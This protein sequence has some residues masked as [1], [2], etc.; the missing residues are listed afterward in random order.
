MGR[1]HGTNLGLGRAFTGMAETARTWGTPLFIG[2]FGM[3]AEIPRA[4]DY[5]RTFYDRLDAAM[6]SGAQWN[7]TPRWNAESRDGWNGEDFSILEPTGSL[8]ANFR[9][10]PYPRATAGMPL[11]FRYE[12]H[13]AP[14][15][16]R[17]LEF[18]WDHD[19]KCGE[20]EIFVPSSLF[21]DGSAIELC[22]PLA[23]CHRDPARQ[24][25]VC[26]S[27]RPGPIRLTVTAPA[28]VIP[29]TAGKVAA[30]IRKIPLDTRV[31][32]C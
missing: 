1:W 22:G 7:Y 10:R 12:D 14:G 16:P 2:E 24:V 21:P 3:G 4:G 6:A 18:E 8:R 30:P 15:R 9:P 19:P 26:R 29:L 13:D 23:A 20:T 28:G 27:P 25:I 32:V 17:S 31:R 5:I 11:R